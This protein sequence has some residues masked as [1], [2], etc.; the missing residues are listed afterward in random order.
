LH[1]VQQVFWPGS[2]SYT[3]GRGE[4]FW[5][6]SSRHQKC[7]RWHCELTRDDG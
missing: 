1:I 3:L 5:S 2:P 4:E 6:V 7:A